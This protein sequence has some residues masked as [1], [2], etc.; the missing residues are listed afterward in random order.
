M[1]KALKKS[2]ITTTLCLSVITTLAPVHATETEDIAAI[3]RELDYLIEFTAQAQKNNRQHK[4]RVQFNY[5]AL[6]SQL[7]LTRE[8][9][10]EFLNTANVQFDTTP[11]SAAGGE[12]IRIGK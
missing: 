5:D 10:A 4:Q 7:N 1:K 11:P 9:T 3:V 12:L 2:L 8:R 6:L